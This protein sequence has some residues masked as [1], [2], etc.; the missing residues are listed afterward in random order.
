MLG[1]EEV[2]LLIAFVDLTR[3]AAQSQRIDDRRLA[4]TLDAFYEH[5]AAAVQAGG[6]TVVKF[7]GDAALIVFSAATVDRGVRVLLALKD[8]VD[9]LMAQRE[10][11]CR[12]TAKVHYGTVIAG[13]FGSSGDKRY[14]V[15]GKAVNKAAILDSA[16]VT[17]SVEAFGKLG[18]D[19]QARFKQATSR[20]SY[21]RAQ[22]L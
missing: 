3:F 2:P 20:T 12:L 11:E 5:V 18:R 9:A 21:I 17:L 22:D 13:P 7:I 1:V 4:E 14:D 16:G 19:L 6:G 10:W 8:S 15:I